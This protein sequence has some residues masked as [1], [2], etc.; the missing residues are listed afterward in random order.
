[1]CQRQSGLCFLELPN[2]NCDAPQPN[3]KVMIRHWAARDTDL[4]REAGSL[5][6]PVVNSSKSQVVAASYP[7]A[8]EKTKSPSVWE[9]LKSG[10]Q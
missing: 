7:R 8:G 3:N 1:M 9:I 6:H 10:V 2:G 4:G 5:T